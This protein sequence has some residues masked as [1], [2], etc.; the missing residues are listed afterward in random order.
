[1][2]CSRT[3]LAFRL[4]H[5]EL[6]LVPVPYVVD[7]IGCLLTNTLKAGNKLLL[8]Q[9]WIDVQQGAL[10]TGVESA[11]EKNCTAVTIKAL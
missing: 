1:M 5:L 11:Q 3:P 6:V 7:H 4:L 2:L 8:G 10:H 9:V